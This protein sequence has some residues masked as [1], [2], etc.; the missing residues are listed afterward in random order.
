MPAQS[1]PRAGLMNGDVAPGL[2]FSDGPELGDKVASHP[3]VSVR[4]TSGGEQFSILK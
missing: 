3:I 2:N 4:Q 1:A